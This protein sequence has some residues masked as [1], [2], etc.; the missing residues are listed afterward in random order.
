MEQTYDRGITTNRSL[1]F[2]WIELTNQCNLQCSHCYA[3]SGHSEP[4][5]GAMTF[6]DY[7]KII[8]D[9]YGV[10]CRKL[11]FIGGEPTINKDMASLIAHA[12][13]MSYDFIEVF[14]NLTRLSDDLL[15]C[16]QI[17][18]VYVATSVY[19]PDAERHDR[20]T[21]VS[22]SFEKT[23]ENIQALLLMH[24]PVRAG[25][26]E[27]EANA[28][29]YDETR[30]LLNDIGIEHV[31]TD[32]MRKFG[33]GSGCEK[34]DLGELCGECG[35]D[36]LCVAPDGK[37]SPCIM[38]KAWPVGSVL[39]APISEIVSSGVL[40]KTRDDIRLATEHRRGLDACDPQTCDPYRSK[41]G[42]IQPTC[43]PCIPNGISAR[44]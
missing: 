34:S 3:G 23:I 35:K 28:G 24:I 4:K 38:S 8:T 21:G 39:D 9:A 42:P 16:F 25:F 5:S 2:L 32:H 13:E 10:G 27:M 15:K 37:V 19:A 20:I 12:S 14:T 41:C 6:H 26:I 36:T 18:K 1:G 17:H 7:E 30:R 43:F 33:R 22:G 29:L 31:G 44:A 40:A 11:Q